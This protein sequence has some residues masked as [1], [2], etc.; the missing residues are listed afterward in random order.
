[1]SRSNL[2][3]SR[4]KL[5]IL[6]KLDNGSS[7]SNSISI[8]ECPYLSLLIADLVLYAVRFSIS[9]FRAH[10]SIVGVCASNVT[11][12]RLL[13]LPSFRVI[14]D[15]RG[16]RRCDAAREIIGP[17]PFRANHDG[18]DRRRRDASWPHVGR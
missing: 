13:G 11:R 14:N 6:A 17:S 3:I 4:R 12:S 5:S 10:G 7:E 9:V 2:A 18:R 15:G 1:M 16:R 8:T